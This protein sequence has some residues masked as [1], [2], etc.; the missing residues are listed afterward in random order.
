MTACF[1]SP[2]ILFDLCTGGNVV[3]W[4][5]AFVLMCLFFVILIDLDMIIKHET[6][7][8]YS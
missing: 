3:C 2:F 5:F 1:I 8:N 6:A 7:L 4:S